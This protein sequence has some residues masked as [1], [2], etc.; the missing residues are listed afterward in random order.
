MGSRTERRA[1]RRGRVEVPH[2]FFF[3]LNFFLTNWRDKN[4]GCVGK[5]AE[6]ISN[7]FI[8]SEVH[9]S[10]TVSRARDSG[11]VRARAR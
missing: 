3:F 6:M 2:I 9:A 1:P 4:I 7:Y 5:K 10:P 8:S 11:G